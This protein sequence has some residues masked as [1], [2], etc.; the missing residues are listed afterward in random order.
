MSVTN[1]LSEIN[2]GFSA[3]L[4]LIWLLVATSSIVLI[5][6]AP[7]DILGITL[8][9]SFFAFGLR[10]PPHLSIALTLL[11][12]FILANIISAMFAPDPFRCVRYM[13]ITL[14]LVLT[15]LFFTSVIY[16]DPERVYEVIWKAYIFAAV[17]AVILGIIGYLKLTPYYELFMNWNRVKGPFKDPNVYGPF[18][19][20]VA[21]YL[22][23]RLEQAKRTQFIVEFLL[24]LFIVTGILLSFSR[25]AWVNLVISIAV[26]VGIRF[27]IA[28]SIKDVFSLITVGGVLLV[29]TLSFIIWLVSSSEVGDVFTQRATLFQKYD[30][31][32]G[33]RFE[34]LKTTAVEILLNPIGR[35]P[36]QTVNIV[37]TT[38]PHN[39]YLHVMLENGWLGGIAFCSFL[40]FTVWNGFLFALTESKLQGP[41]IVVFACVTGTLLESLII[42]STHW[43]HL[44]L[45]L[46][47]VW[48]PMV[49]REKIIVRKCQTKI[50]RRDN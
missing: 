3:R 28:Q 35:G 4:S 44:Y 43:R 46:A 23:F 39:L 41:F 45:L 22:A 29:V 40:L 25:G 20:P 36:G 6:P 8:F 48:G 17:I 9:I 42:H 18:L 14:F 27:F 26:Y 32:S 5:E 10:I 50:R 37:G 49:A 11:T 34:T 2:N 19:I 31:S 47:M 33:G 13:S 24:L 15:W 12:V 7:Y 1:D 16:D 30:V 38:D 21:L